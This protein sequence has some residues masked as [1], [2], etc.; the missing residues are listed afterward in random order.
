MISLKILSAA[1]ILSFAIPVVSSTAS[2]AQ[3]DPKAG[4]A[5]GG[6]GGG[7]GPRMGG[8]GGGG[9]RMGM[10]GG[11]AG[12]RMGAGVG[13]GPRMGMGGGGGPR[14]QGGGGGGGPRFSGGGGPRYGGGGWRG[15]NYGGAVLPGVVAGAV[16]GGALASPYYGYGGYG[17]YGA[18]D[19]SYGYDDG[20]AVQIVPGGD[21]SEAYC[22]QRFRSYDPASGTYLGNDGLRHPCP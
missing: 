20:P 7:A 11:G 17:G 21:D 22:V 1:A 15:R 8:G 10:G 16:I 9:P 6:G 2:F 3:G 12:P 19:D 13:G 4:A 5:R 14:F 18:Y